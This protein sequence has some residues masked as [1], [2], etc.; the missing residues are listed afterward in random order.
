MSAQSFCLVTTFYPPYNFGGDGIY[1]YRQANALARRD[2]PVQVI[3]TPDAFHLLAG[4]DPALIEKQ[5]LAYPPH[6]N[7]TVHP[8]ETPP[9]G[10]LDML[11]SHQLGRPAGIA[12]QL[13]SLLEEQHFDVVHFHNISLL[14]GPQVLQYGR[15]AV[16]LCTLHDYWFVCAMHVLWRFNREACT[17]RTC[18]AC[19]LHGRR[20]PQVWRYSGRLAE[21][22]QHVQAFISPSRSACLLHQA[23]RFPAPIQVLPHFLPDAE[24]EAGLNRPAGDAHPRP[25]FLFAGRLEKIKGVQNLLALFGRYD[26]ADLL[27]AGTGTYEATLRQQAEGLA[28]VHFLGQLDPGTLRGLYAQ[29]LA[30]L[31]PSICYETFGWTTLESFAA[32]TPAI[33]NNMGALPEV[34]EQG[35]GGFVYEDS[36]GLLEAMEKLRN[37]PELRAKMG[38]EGYASY[39]RYYTEERHMAA[40]FEL[41][42]SVQ[43]F[44]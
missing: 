29:A 36:A 28:H 41:I 8:I 38:Q 24:V 44:A 18:L 15:P 30:T 4:D 23:N 3:H 2:H 16:K 40:Y 12:P 13:Q 9:L 22:V 17:R 6:P 10:R 27:I 26:K 39:E 25:F 43:Q 42:G 35:G 11:L 34:I 7:I 37:D 33:V 20:P 5:R 14:G 19:T 21:D 32:R 31:V 1:V